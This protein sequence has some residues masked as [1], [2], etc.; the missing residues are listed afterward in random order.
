MIISATEWLVY[1]VAVGNIVAPV[2][3]RVGGDV[4]VCSRRAVCLFGAFNAY[5]I[6][7]TPARAINVAETLLARLLYHIAQVAVCGNTP[8]AFPASQGQQTDPSQHTGL[9]GS[10]EQSPSPRHPLHM[11]ETVS[12]NGPVGMPTQSSLFLHPTHS[13]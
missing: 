13:S 8:P 6:E 3:A 7:T 1:G 2:D 11:P 12:Q 5:I 10:P 4:T 9:F